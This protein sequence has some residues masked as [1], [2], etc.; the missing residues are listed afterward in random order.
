MSR[1][2]NLGSLALEVLPCW[3]RNG[4][5]GVR[6]TFPTSKSLS[7]KDVFEKWPHLSKMEILCADLDPSSLL[8]NFRH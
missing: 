1:V 7:K 6:F 2:I 3:Q 5:G 4:S 8:N